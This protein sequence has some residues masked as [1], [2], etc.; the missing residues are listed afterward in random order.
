MSATISMA[1]CGN[2][3]VSAAVGINA[4]RSSYVQKKPLATVSNMPFELTD[5][6]NVRQQNRVL[7]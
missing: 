6:P 3:T 2:T 4:T 5:E 1:A 7:V